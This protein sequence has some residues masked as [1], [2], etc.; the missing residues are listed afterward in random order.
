MSRLRLQ[1]YYEIN[2]VIADLF[3]KQYDYFAQIQRDAVVRPLTFD[4]NIDYTLHNQFRAIV[5]SPSPSHSCNLNS[6]V[7]Q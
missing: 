5:A 3:R 6:T 1:M 4:L 2:G 7:H